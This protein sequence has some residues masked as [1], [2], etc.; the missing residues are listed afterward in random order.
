MAVPG[1]ESRGS[2]HHRRPD[3]GRAPP[4]GRGCATAVHRR[5]AAAPDPCRHSRPQRSAGTTPAVIRAAHDDGHPHGPGPH[6]QRRQ[7]AARTSSCAGP[8]Q[9]APPL[10]RA[11]GDSGRPGRRSGGVPPERLDRG[12]VEGER[13]RRAR[14]GFGPIVAAA[15]FTALEVDR[16]ARCRIPAGVRRDRADLPDPSYEFDLRNGT[17]APESTAAWY[18]ART[19]D[20]FEFPD[21]SDAYIAYDDTLS[22][23]GCE[24]ESTASR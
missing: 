23:G 18:L 21:D 14:P 24:E 16:L 22:P 8:A 7:R 17:V 4:S 2:A 6:G 5:L 11:D 20:A 19:A 1:E 12:P 3:R 13:P 15:L 10:G 9:E